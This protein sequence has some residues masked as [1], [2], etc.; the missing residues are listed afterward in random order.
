[1]FSQDIRSILTASGMTQKVFAAALGIP[2]R[3]LESYLAGVREPTP[4]T[5]KALLEAA[6][7]I[8]KENK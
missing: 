1:M 4:F 5:Q 7:K 8:E 2:L 6:Q 3:T